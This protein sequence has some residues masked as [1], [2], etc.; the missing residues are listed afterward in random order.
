MYT[1]NAIRCQNRNEKER[2]RNKTKQMN[3]EYKEKPK[4][5]ILKLICMLIALSKATEVS[6]TFIECMSNIFYRNM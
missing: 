4:I 1:V 6:A 2:E 3:T 5:I